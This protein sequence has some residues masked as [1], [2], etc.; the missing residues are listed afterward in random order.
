MST[1]HEF[2]DAKSTDGGGPA[3]SVEMTTQSTRK[4]FTRST[5]RLHDSKAVD[6]A[7]REVPADGGV[8]LKEK[9]EG[10]TTVTKTPAMIW[11]ARIDFAALCFT[12]FLAGWDSGTAGPLIPRF[13]L[14]YNVNFTIV[15]LIF[16]MNCV[17]FLLGAATN[18]FLTERLGFG[19]VLV[20]GSLAQTV[21]YI[22]M[23]P[24]LPFSVF[25]IAFLINGWGISLQ[26]AQS[27]SFVAGL[28][29]NSSAKMGIM[30]AL[31][32]FG[33]VCS[34]FAATQF[35][36]MPKHWSYHF[37]ISTGIATIN[38]IFL[39]LAFKGKTIDECFLEIGEAATEQGTSDDSKYKQILTNKVV[40]LLAF[41][42][43]VYVGIEITIGGWT[44]SYLQK[45]RG[46]GP[47][48]GYVS[49]GFFGG[50]T[51][52]RVLLLQVN[53]K[54]GEHLIIYIYTL[55]ALGLELVVWLVPNLIADAVAVSF[56][57][58]VLGPMYP[59]LMNETGRLVPQ[60]L[61]TGSIGWIASFGFAGSALFPF[62]TGALAERFGIV[63]LQPLLI[64]LYGVMFVLWL[65]V[66]N[67][68]R[69]T[70]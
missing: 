46:G 30:H 4:S 26:D 33:A 21:G 67:G 49:T 12:L 41:W 52:G 24:A 53:E 48:S 63:S 58:F 43:L 15:S 13:Q 54:V 28:S 44:V 35:A 29:E 1:I 3:A 25:C 23:A 70:T 19:K 10:N 66:P 27:N 40:H 7:T 36:Q 61:L 5:S 59:I 50:L 22:L 31:Y 18:V 11:K 32:G 57:G 39:V 42:S 38:T 8:A 17:G 16:I 69:R 6:V 37:I 2:R 9:D 65:L 55:L 14:F 20:L 47:S 64:I 68:A 62:A 60:W 56:V 51:L 34:P 45:H